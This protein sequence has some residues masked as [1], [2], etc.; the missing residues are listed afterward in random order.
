MRPETA[1]PAAPRRVARRPAVA[2]RCWAPRALGIAL[3][4][5]ALASVGPARIWASLRLADPWPLIPAFLLALPFIAVKAWRWSGLVAGL[6]LPAPGR[7]EAYRLYAIGLFAGQVTPGQA[8]DF[9]KAWYLRGRGAPLAAA[10]LS[11]LLDRLF[12]LAALLGL[13]AVALLAVASGGGS[14]LVAAFGFVGACVALAAIMTDRWRAPLIA[15]LG[16][17]LPGPLRARAAASPTLRSLATLRLDA[18]RLWP[19][20]GWT[21][22]SWIIAL[23]RVWL[24]FIALDIRLPLADFALVTVLQGVASLI[25][26]GGIGTRDVVLLTFLARYGYDSGRA[27]ALAFL[28]LALNLSNI[29]P[30]FLLWFREPAPLR[31]GNPAAEIEGEARPVALAAGTGDR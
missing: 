10:L 13:G 15:L 12:D 20:L 1:A 29:V 17:A 11:C 27:L 31:P 5:L 24:C 2:L 7:A 14:L 6:D 18:R 8:G 16:R 30:G 28:I 25:S 26:I 3:F 23:G 9:M 19:A 4:V 21:A 22:L